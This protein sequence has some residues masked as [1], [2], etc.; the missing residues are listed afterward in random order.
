MYTVVKKKYIEE[1]EKDTL[2]AQ[3]DKINSEKKLKGKLERI[4]EAFLYIKEKRLGKTEILEI[5][6]TLLEE[7][8]N[9][10]SD[11]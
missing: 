4:L 5:I 8:F 6:D 10:E 2:A 1:L 11:Q 9:Y 7:E 3:K